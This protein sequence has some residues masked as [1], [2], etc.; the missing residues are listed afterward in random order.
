[1]KKLFL[2]LSLP[3][4][5]SSC[6]PTTWTIPAHVD[7]CAPSQHSFVVQGKKL[8]VHY[9]LDL[10]HYGTQ[11]HIILKADPRGPG[12]APKEFYFNFDITEDGKTKTPI[13]YNANRA[14]LTIHMNG[15]MQTISAFPALFFPH[16]I[17]Y[18]VQPIPFRLAGRV[19]I[20]DDSLNQSIG[21]PHRNGKTHTQ[22]TGR[23]VVA[24]VFPISDYGLKNSQTDWVIHLGEIEVLGEKIVLPDSKLCRVPE[25]KQ[26]SIEPIMKV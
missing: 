25:R 15:K 13:Y 5:I 14:T 23:N 18:S 6:Y 24:V 16:D 9:S 26:L 11:S 3:I 20:Q 7:I 8:T 2:L 4:I 21:A 17:N 22:L 1:M 10:N 12:Y 19:N